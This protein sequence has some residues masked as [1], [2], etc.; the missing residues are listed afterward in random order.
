VV[1]ISDILGVE[2]AKVLELLPGDDELLLRAGIGWR[3]GLVGRANVATGPDSQAGY[4]LTAGRPVI[5]ENFATEKRFAGQPLLRDHGVRSGISVPIAGMDGRAYGVI[6]AHSARLVKF[7]DYDVSFLAAVANVLAGAIRRRQLD[8]RH[9]MMIRELR[10]RS[11]NVFA[12]LLALFAQTA[13]SSRSVR[14]LTSKFEG[15]VLALA[16]AHRLV[17]EAGWTP[18]S[19]TRLLNT[20]FAQHLGRVTFQ[21]ADIQLEP[22]SAFGL[23]MALHELITNATQHGSLCSHGGRVNVAWLVSRTSLGPTLNLEWKEA[24]GAAPKRNPRSGFGLRVVKM[25]IERQ[26]NGRCEHVFDKHGL[27]ARLSVPLTQER[28]TQFLPGSANAAPIPTPV[29]QF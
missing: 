20:Q 24:G 2:F 22:D 21:G 9:E 17:T 16:T 1:S 14:D 29:S 15:R 26:L 6:S 13:K 19:L 27:I 18:I 5:V 23:S 7:H 4:T 25:A 3:E 12:Q 10:H 28:W 8:H 11:G